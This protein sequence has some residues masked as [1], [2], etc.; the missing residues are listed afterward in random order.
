LP[1]GFVLQTATPLTLA[2][3]LTKGKW[4]RPPHLAHLE[5]VLMTMVAGKHRRVL[6]TMPPRH[7]KSETC[8]HWFLTWFLGHFPDQRVILASYEARFAESWGRKVR[9]SLNEC[10]TQGLFPHGVNDRVSSVSEWQVEGHGGGMITAGVGG[11]ITGRGGNLLIDDPVKNAEEANSP[12]YREKAWDWY[13]STASTRLEP[14]CWQLLIL[15]RWHEDDMA[16]RNLAQF[17]EDWL[18][19]NFPALAEEADVLGRQPGEALWP[20]RFTTADLEGQ[21]AK[22]GSYWF[23]ALY[24]QR[25]TA[26]EGGFFRREWLP[27]IPAPP[28]GVG[29]ER[30]RWW[31]AAATED[32]GDYTV[33]VKMARTPDGLFVVEDVKHGQWSPAT[34][35]KIILQ[36]AQT[37]GRGVKVREEQE[38]G[39]SGKAVVASRARLLTGFD[40]RGIPST[41]D[42]QVR[43]APFAA[44][45]EAGNVRLVAGDWNAAYIDEL[46][47]F[48]RG[49]N[50][51]QVDG[52]SGAFGRLA[53]IEPITSLPVFV[54]R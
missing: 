54:R 18:V 49:A 27:I 42:K 13:L 23:N 52:S 29:V 14:N 30:V 5:D 31:D 43:A 28:A 41:G 7:G 50:D 19:V 11:A 10:K 20:A 38:P 2:Y 44:Q 15:T 26:R 39:S 45:C 36:T 16:G 9:D 33:G 35:D 22:L 53:P 21:K 46:C 48:P 24:Q 17:P 12:V 32:G 47:A 4:K 34:V 40:Y 3:T 1:L 8:S 25:P 37:D 51:D 6:V